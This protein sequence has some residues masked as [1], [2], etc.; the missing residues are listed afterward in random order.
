MQKT[1]SK[2]TNKKFEIHLAFLTLIFFVVFVLTPYICKTYLNENLDTVVGTV[3]GTKDSNT[4]LTKE[5]IKEQLDQ[6]FLKMF[7]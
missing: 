1:A 2:K 5:S 3:L 6:V 7:N 4:K